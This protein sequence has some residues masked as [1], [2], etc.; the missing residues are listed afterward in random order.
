MT[1]HGHAGECCVWDPEAMSPRKDAF[2][3]RLGLEPAP[4]R[5]PSARGPGLTRPVLRAG[6]PAGLPC[7]QTKPLSFPV[8][9]RSGEAQ[10]RHKHGQE[11]KPPESFQKPLSDK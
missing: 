2:P 8:V 11:G 9:R 10:W 7:C 4:G 3:H 1:L 5:D 6:P